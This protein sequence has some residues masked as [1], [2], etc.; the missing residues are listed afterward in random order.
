MNVKTAKASLARL[1]GALAAIAVLT[2]FPAG[3]AADNAYVKSV[4]SLPLTLDP[5]KMNDTSSLV[6]GNLLY[7][8]LLRFSSTLSIEGAL[9]ESWST[10]PDG[11]TLTF[12]L[13]QARFHN[14]V[15]ITATD[16]VT[17]L[18][19]ALSQESAVRKYY[20]CIDDSKGRGLLAKDTKTVKIHLKHPF[21]P[22]L[23]VL[24]GATAKI[25]PGELVGKP[26]FFERPVG[27]GAFQFVG[28]VEAPTKDL[29]L[30][31]FNDYHSG[32][33]KLDKLVLREMVENDAVKA[34][35][36]GEVQ[37]LANW[38]LTADSD[39]FK[40]G[41]NVTSPVAATW[42]I[43]MNSRKA[44]FR[45]KA[46][47][48]RFRADLDADGFRKKFFP[49]AIRAHGYV[50]PGLPGYASSSQPSKQLKPG[51][52]PQ[53]KI[54]IVIPEELARAAEMRAYLEESLRRKGWNA[55]VVT[56]AWAELMKGYEGKTHQAFLVS[57]NMDYPDTEFLLR[58]F[59]S[60]NPDNFSGIKDK[61][62]DALLKEARTHRDRKRRQEFYRE[63]ISLIDGE[64][65]TVNLF[66]PRANYWVSNC[67][68][69]FEP[70]ILADVYI[71]YEKV[72]L[73]NGCSGKLVSR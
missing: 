14:G 58:N 30:A 11:R 38:P 7:D 67:V 18:R 41:K 48:Q 9:A 47:R 28:R 50:P 62:L 66:H 52:P 23:S 64:A 32:K 35:L 70:N 43:G 17:S 63:A 2:L 71:N 55:S 39:V 68:E 69:G 22:F 65:L 60:G 46:T 42:I 37:D 36:A 53:N 56:M 4:Y 12:V 44:P 51:R 13:R 25:L 57:M 72:S 8:G 26:G 21:P 73:T 20:D 33:P 6:A 15:P 49:E 10:S 1:K 24:A 54:R 40:A 61:K 5:I 31:G 59:E 16:V 3:Y 34:A 29:V 45:S 27:S 19:R